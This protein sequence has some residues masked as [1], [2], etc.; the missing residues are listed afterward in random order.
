MLRFEM[1]HGIA[2]DEL[3]AV[4]DSWAHIQVTSR[5]LRTAFADAFKF[6]SAAQFS[7]AKFQGFCRQ[8]NGSN[9]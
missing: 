2:S 6:A 1:K 7:A 8:E 9:A 3:F 4:M 5:M